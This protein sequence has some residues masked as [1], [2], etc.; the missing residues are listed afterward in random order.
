MY[1]WW[2]APL[3]LLLRRQRQV[4]FLFAWGQPGLQW[5]IL[6]PKTVC[7]YV[8]M[9]VHALFIILMAETRQSWSHSGSNCLKR[10]TLDILTGNGEESTLC[11][12]M[13]KYWLLMY[14]RRE[15]SFS[16]VGY[17]LS[18]RRAPWVV[19][20]SLPHRRSCL[21]SVSLGKRKG[22]KCLKVH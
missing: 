16:L 18:T 9:Y 12:C 14:S 19:E 17:P 6:S 15:D 13:L 5:D 21:N 1:N 4:D 7:M 2:P 10:T 22:K 8:Y 11:L 3:I 20:H